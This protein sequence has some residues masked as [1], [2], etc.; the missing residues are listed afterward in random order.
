MMVASPTAKANCRC[1]ELHCGHDFESGCGIP[2]SPK[3]TEWEN[4]S[5]YKGAR[6]A[7]FTKLFLPEFLNRISSIVIFNRLTKREIRKIVDVR[8]SEIQLRLKS[9]G[10]DVQINMSDD[11]RDYLASAGYSPAYGARRLRV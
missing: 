1:E 11:V 8:L 7:I 10:R 4:R 6:H 3:H 9:N 5:H 2:G